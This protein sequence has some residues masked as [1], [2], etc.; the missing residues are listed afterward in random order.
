[1]SETP[2]EIRFWRIVTLLDLLEGYAA[3][4]VVV[5]GT[6]GQAIVR[7]E[8]DQIVAESTAGQ[9]GKALGQL[10]DLAKHLNLRSVL[11]HSERVHDA[12]SGGTPVQQ[13]YLRQLVM[14][15]LQ[16]TAE[17]LQ[18]MTFLVI[19]PDFS[20]LYRQ[21]A[22]PFGQEVV[23][24]FPRATEDVSE[25]A[26]CLALNRST[27]AVFHLMRAMECAVQAL[28][29]KLAIPNTERVWGMLLSDIAKKIETLPKDDQRTKWSEVH[30]HLYHVKEAWRNDTMHPKQTYT[31]EEAQAIFTAVKTFM[32]SLSA[33]V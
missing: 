21:S 3:T 16:R 19:P 18:D 5:S 14:E 33:L 17:E 2:W 28:A 12:L 13:Q 29:A 24:A 31:T 30:S 9:I 22:K 32:R 10:R 15:A 20:L 27:A 8:K 25:S 23:D 6:L 7:L 4:F 11:R 26:K 1:M